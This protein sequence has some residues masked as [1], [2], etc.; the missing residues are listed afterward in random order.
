MF[1]YVRPASVWKADGSSCRL[2]H[3]TLL[4]PRNG[5][6][7]LTSETPAGFVSVRFRSGALRHFCRIP[8]GELIDQS[9]SAG[10]IWGHAGWEVETR[11]AD[12]TGISERIRII[13]DFLLRQWQNNRQTAHGWLDA[14]FHRLYHHRDGGLDLVQADAGVSVRQ[15]QKVF[16]LYA[17][18]SPKY[19][20]RVARLEVIVRHLLIDRQRQYLDLALAHG[21]YDQAHF[22]RDFK[23]FT[24]D[25]PSRFLCE[26]NF[27]THFYNPSLRA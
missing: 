20:Q 4:S 7:A 12:A 17:G 26:A 24:G 15:F 19:F 21:F 10:D 18:V 6:F 16:K 22:I 23:R 5:R 13:E 25:T 8:P 9:P 1:H 11:V 3:A 27:R 2:P 14:A